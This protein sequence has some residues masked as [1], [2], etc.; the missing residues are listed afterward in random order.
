MSELEQLEKKIES[1]P[2][3]E[4]ARFRAWFAEFDAGAWDAQIEADAAAGALDEWIAEGLADYRNGKAR[5]I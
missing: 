4:L 5:K 1:L 3:D 2:P